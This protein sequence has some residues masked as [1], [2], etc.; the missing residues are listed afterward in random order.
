MRLPAPAKVN[1][2]L[3]VRRRRADGYHEIETV[4]A[5]LAWHDTVAAAP[6]DALSLTCSDPALPTD[7]GNLVWQAAEALAG[8]A[9]IAPAAALHLDKRV[10]YGAGLGSGSSDAAATLRLLAELWGL[11][12]PA[13]AMHAL[14]AGLGADVPFFLVGRAASATGIGEAL[15][16]LAG[17]DGAPWRCP[18]WLV[19]AVPD[20]HVPTGPAYGWVTPDDAPRPPLAEAVLS[21]DL[22]RWRR[23]LTND[24]EAPV[25]ARFPA[26]G[27]ALDGLRAAGAG[28]A[29]MSGSGSAVVG[30]FEGEGAARA[31]ADALAAAGCRVH[32]EGP[33]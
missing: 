2:G 26:V 3:R 12:V 10:P 24:F 32:A 7:G 29:A 19:V 21:D 5:P 9:G 4:F 1:L 15:T 20:A 16:P 18:F 14:A 6:A 28:W 30:A 17:A 8:W 33:G 23:E 11:D 25:V 31:A 27:A 22:A 13:A